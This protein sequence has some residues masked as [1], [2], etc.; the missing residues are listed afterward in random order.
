MAKNKLLKHFNSSDS[1]YFTGAAVQ[2]RCFDLA[3]LIDGELL[4]CVEIDIA[5]QKLVE[6]QDWALK[7]AEVKKEITEKLNS[8]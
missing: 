1:D 4:D 7:A 8:P 6:V 5:L 2:E 3:M